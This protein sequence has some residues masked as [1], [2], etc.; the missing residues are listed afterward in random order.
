MLLL[1][2]VATNFYSITFPVGASMIPTIYFDGE[3]ILI[4]HLYR[5]G[6][7]IKVGDVICSLHPLFP[8]GTAIVKRVAGMPG[9]FVWVPEGAP[10]DWHEADGMGGGGEPGRGRMIQVP[11]GHCWVLGDNQAFS[12]DSRLYG[13]LPLGLITGKIMWRIWPLRRWGPVANTME[14]VNEEEL[15]NF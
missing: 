13:P 10:I 1:H 8:G 2:F 11:R 6:K 4:S 9:D 15:F 12:R 3:C 14:E 5:H 7:G